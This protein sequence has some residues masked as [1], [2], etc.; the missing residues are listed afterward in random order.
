MTEDNEAGS[1]VAQANF[2]LIKVED[3]LELLICWVHRQIPSH[4]I[5]MVLGNHT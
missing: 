5:Y 3:D 2:K 4:S 1:L